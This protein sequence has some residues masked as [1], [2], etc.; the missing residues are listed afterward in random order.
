MSNIREEYKVNPTQEY[1]GNPTQDS[2]ASQNT[3][4]KKQPYDIAS[5]PFGAEEM[6]LNA[7]LKN[8]DGEER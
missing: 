2:K 6:L 8:L 4:L 3:E 1:K 7:E 5:Y